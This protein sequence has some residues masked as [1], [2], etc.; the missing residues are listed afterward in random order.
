MYRADE[1]KVTGQNDPMSPLTAN[2]AG[3]TDNRYINRHGP[4]EQMGNFSL[5][6]KDKHL[7]PRCHQILFAAGMA[8]L[9]IVGPVLIALTEWMDRTPDWTPHAVIMA[10]LW[11]AV[12]LKA[13][14]IIKMGN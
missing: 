8:V 5:H 2:L 3:R 4:V 7:V 9:F 6:P 1:L 14:P 13:P 11:T 10:T 12:A